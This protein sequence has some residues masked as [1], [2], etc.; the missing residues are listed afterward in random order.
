MSA[1]QVAADHGDAG[2][3]Q[4]SHTANSNGWMWPLSWLFGSSEPL[5]EEVSQPKHAA[6]RW[7][8]ATVH[9]VRFSQ[10]FI[11]PMFTLRFRCLQ[12]LAEGFSRGMVARYGDASPAFLECSAKSALQR[13]KEQFELLLV[14]VHSELHQDTE[15]FVRY[16]FVL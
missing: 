11:Q 3:D 16:V 7:R 4:H 13:A 10:H 15:V 6:Q 9:V 1:D 5:S 14:Y 2:A 8:N 12:L